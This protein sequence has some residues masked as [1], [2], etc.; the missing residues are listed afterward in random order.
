MA[1]LSVLDGIRAIAILLVVACHLLL[2]V[3]TGASPYYDLR[4]MGHLGVAIFFVHTTWVLMASLERHGPAVIPFYVRRLLRIYPLPV[5]ILLFMAALQFALNMPIDTKRLLSNLLLVQNITGDQPYIGPLWS[6][7]YEVQMYLVLP[8]LY[9]I[10]SRPRRSVLWCALLYAASIVVA[11]SDSANLATFHVPGTNPSLLRF[12]PCFIAGALAF[13]LARRIP[14]VLPPRGLAILMACVIALVPWLVA[15]GVPEAPVL[16]GTCLLLGCTIP[17]CRELTS[18]PIIGAA[19]T[20]ATYSYGVYL[21]HVFA[22]SAIDGLITGSRITQ[23]AVLLI[24]LPGLAYICYH[25]IEKR[26]IALGA[27]LAARFAAKSERQ[28]LRGAPNCD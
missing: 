7:P 19:K 22:F 17:A 26:G 23:W 8:P 3:K 2:Q 16:W 1:H 12:A 18:R 11:A 21:T 4:A 28:D 9:A 20:V 10:V 13:A 25:G 6:L 24:L 5:L 15:V 27:H 14:R